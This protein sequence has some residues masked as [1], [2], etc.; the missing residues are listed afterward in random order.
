M[1]HPLHILLIHQVFVRPDD[2]GGTRH[3][4]F[5]HHLVQRGHK[6]TVLA[7][8]RSYLTGEP[9]RTP[10]REQLEPGLQL[11]RC[12]VA[13]GRRR[14][15]V[16]R[17]VGFLSFML[18]AFWR[19]LRLRGVDVVW[20]TSP[21]LFQGCSAWA[22]ARLK[23]APWLFEIRDLWPEFAIEIGAL[24]SR[25]L[26][27]L[28]RWLER[29]LYRRASRLVVNSPAFAPFLEQAGAAAEKVVTVPNGVD[30]ERFHAEA[31]AAG[32][33]Q[34]H[35]LEGKFLALYAGAHGVAND[36]WQVLQ[37]ADALK[38]DPGIV[39]VLLGDGAEKSQL[40]AHAQA[41]GLRNV[42]FLP[43]I[44]KHG[45]PGVLV[46]ADCGIATLKPLK[47]FTTTYPNKVF[48]YMAA[49]KPVVLA[50]DGAI[51]ELVEVAQAG[52]Y[53]PP[54]DGQ[55]L[56]QAVLRLR[57]EPALAERLGRNGRQYVAAHYDRRQLAERMQ[58]ELESLVE[59]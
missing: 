57:A 3:Y 20:G 55:A 42:L 28:S 25:T 41:H 6:V 46:E 35:G 53:V 56:A 40:M 8:T 4:E 17:T 52:L 19:G 23:R 13:G 34:A 36:L 32:L 44:S 15:A 2:P 54:G 12:W 14:S 58:H 26:I 29:F 38:Q 39:F 7:G 21:P 24:R 33:R 45:I 5:A 37:A 27:G 10:R 59:G 18:S 48:D 51:R 49:A 30:T 11:V 1:P 47:M 31:P 50:I 22:L 9:L 16:W 43:P